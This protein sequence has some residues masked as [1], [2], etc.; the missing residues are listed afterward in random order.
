MRYPSIAVEA[1]PRSDPR[2]TELGSG[3]V[4]AP[5][6]IDPTPYLSLDTLQE[7]TNKQSSI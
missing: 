4:G 6:M 1:R 7:S 3:E 2:S 5:A